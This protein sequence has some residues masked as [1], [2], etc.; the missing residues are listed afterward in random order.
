MFIS[1][2]NIIEKVFNDPKYT[3]FYFN[4]F[5]VY[6][7]MQYGLILNLKKINEIKECHNL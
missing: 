3:L 7:A 2:T 6:L 1:K 4:I 5:E